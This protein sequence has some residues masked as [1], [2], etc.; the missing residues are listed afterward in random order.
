MYVWFLYFYALIQNS[1]PTLM[2]LCIDFIVGRFDENGPP[3]GGEENS[4]QFLSG[5]VR[6]KLMWQLLRRRKLTAVNS[7]VWIWY[8]LFYTIL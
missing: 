8:S 1:V 4:V 2:D 3:N 6:E 7:L 5:D